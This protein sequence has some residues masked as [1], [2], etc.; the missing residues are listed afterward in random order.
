VE[1]RGKDGGPRG[2][3]KRKAK[4]LERRSSSVEFLARAKMN[5][6]PWYRINF[7]RVTRLMQV[8]CVLLY[9]TPLIFKYDD[10][11]ICPYALV[12]SRGPAEVAL[13]FTSKIS[14][15]LMYPLLVVIILSKCATFRTFIQFT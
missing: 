3:P 6:K 9:T 15:L 2:E 14:G 7:E 13:L 12:C 10:G 1:G 11:A 8:L 5:K 4:K